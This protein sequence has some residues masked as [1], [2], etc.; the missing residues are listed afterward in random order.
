MSDRYDKFLVG[1]IRRAQRRVDAGGDG[2]GGGDD[3]PPATLRPT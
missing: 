2:V 3:G 1:K